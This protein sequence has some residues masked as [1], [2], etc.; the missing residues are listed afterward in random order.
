MSKKTTLIEGK[1]NKAIIFT[2][3]IDKSAIDQ[4]KSLLNLEYFKDSKISIMPDV[5][6]GAGCVIGLTMTLN[7]YVIPNL[8]GVDIGCGMLTMKI[9]KSNLKEKINQKILVD[10]NG[11]I[12][13]NFEMFD[14]FIKKNIPSGFDKNKNID[15]RINNND[16]FIEDIIKIHVKDLYK[17]NDLKINKIENLDSFID[18]VIKISEKVNINPEEQ[19][20]AIGSLGGGNH[21]IEIDIDDEKNLYIVIHTGSRHFGWQIAN[22]HQ[23][24]A[25]R[26]CEKK[27]YKVQNSLA[28]LEGIEKEEYLNDMLIAQLYAKINR[29]IIALRIL[30]YLN[31]DIKE[32]SYFE[33]IHNYINFKDK[34]IR[35]G[36][37]SAY[38][39]EKVLIPLNM[40][41][42]SLICIGKGNL[43]WNFSAP[44]GAGRIMSRNEA[45][46]KLS[47]NDFKES[48]KGIFS[49]TISKDTIDE[50]PFVYKPINEIIERISDTVEI[51]KIIKPIFNFKA[52]E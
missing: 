9:N 49:T 41:D 39:G 24:K 28:F 20:R 27:G 2:D 33:T 22:F 17:N 44:H 40:R 50:A 4:I 8:V 52:P 37:I 19:L 32:I 21:F 46:K 10:L 31:L 18:K 34:I 43:D 35:K 15:E 13:I 45:K 38:K 36:A 48:M 26:Y 16:K 1:Y 12:N 29:F 25:K 23:N 3:I 30:N 14:N 7:N 51:E 6:A 5:H 47:L 42:G 11:E